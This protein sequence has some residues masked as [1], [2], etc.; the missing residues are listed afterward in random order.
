MT[1][2]YFP[3]SC[4]ELFIYIGYPMTSGGYGLRQRIKGKKDFEVMSR[5]DLQELEM[6][7]IEN[8]DKIKPLSIEEN[9]IDQIVF[10][11]DELESWE[12]TSDSLN[13][14]INWLMREG[15]KNLKNN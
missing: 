8:E 9:L 14:K 2:V 11:I 15:A 5:E 12:S 3:R 7:L 1:D 6:D 10:E 4:C 13:E